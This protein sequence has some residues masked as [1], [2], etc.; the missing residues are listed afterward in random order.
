V[1][2]AIAIPV[3]TSQIERSR[4]GTDLANVRSAYAVVKSAALEGNKD[5]EYEGQKLLAADGKTYSCTIA[6]EQREDGWSMEAPLTVGGITSGTN[7]GTNADRTWVGQPKGKN[8]RCVVSFALDGKMVLNWGEGLNPDDVA[9][10]LNSANGASRPNNYKIDGNSLKA[11]NPDLYEALAASGIDMDKAKLTVTSTN[12]TAWFAYRGE[13]GV[14]RQTVFVYD[15]AMPAITQKNPPTEKDYKEAGFTKNNAPGD[16]RYYSQPLEG[17]VAVSYDSKT[18]QWVPVKDA[19]V[20]LTYI[21]AGGVT[22]WFL[23][24]GGKEV[25]LPS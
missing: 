18:K 9:S 21:T 14:A 11:S 19:Q 15:G 24:P 16:G 13:D 17:A 2:V 1:L 10:S 3:F 7:G 5:A 23:T 25:S 4:E 20:S 6:L 8:G 22:G 12:P